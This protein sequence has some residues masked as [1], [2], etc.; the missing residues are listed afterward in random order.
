MIS[1][2]ETFCTVA[3]LIVAYI[4]VAALFYAVKHDS[5]ISLWAVFTLL[6]FLGLLL[7]S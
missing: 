6:V 7:M 1:A 4:L 3:S 2:L 5:A